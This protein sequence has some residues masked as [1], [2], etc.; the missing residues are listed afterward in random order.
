VI[1]A[2]DPDTGEVLVSA[3][4]EPMPLPDDPDVI[5]RVDTGKKVPGETHA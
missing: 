4:N 1:E 3:T 5:I 2:I